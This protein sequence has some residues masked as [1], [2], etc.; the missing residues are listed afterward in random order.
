MQSHQSATN[1]VVGRLKAFFGDNVELVMS[2]QGSLPSRSSWRSFFVSVS[3]FLVLIYCF[4]VQIWVIVRSIKASQTRQTNN[5]EM[6]KQSTA[7]HRRLTERM[8]FEG[9]PSRI[10][11]YAACFLFKLT[12]TM[13]I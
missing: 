12:T 5:S 13:I 11:A 4:G 6:S 8:F 1:V 9:C 10:Q 7:F 2:D 3:S